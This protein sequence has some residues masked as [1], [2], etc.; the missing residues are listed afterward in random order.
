MIWNSAVLIDPAGAILGVY[1]KNFPTLDEMAAGTRPCTET[2]VFETDFG[3]L[4]LCICFDLNYWEVGSG[5]C[6]LLLVLMVG[7]ANGAQGRGDI[8][9]HWGFDGQLAKRH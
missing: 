9:S 7:V 4:G 2:P 5:L 6:A 1:H 3:R 8:A